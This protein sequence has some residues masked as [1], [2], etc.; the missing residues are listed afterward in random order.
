MED[1]ENQTEGKQWL[2]TDDFAFLR[3]VKDKMVLVQSVTEVTSFSKAAQQQVATDSFPG[4]NDAATRT[5][6]PEIHF[7]SLNL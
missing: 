2:S 5:A 7:C 6:S 1:E 3:Y 4:K